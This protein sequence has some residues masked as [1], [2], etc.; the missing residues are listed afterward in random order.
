MSKAYLK[1]PI[2]ILE[3]VASENGICE[4]NF[5]DKFEK[6]A[7]KDENLRQKLAKNA[8]ESANL[9]SKEN[10]IKQWREFIKKVVSK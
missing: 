10:I 6:I 9:F 5:V 1:S 4:I 3:I 7:V 8:S 2:G